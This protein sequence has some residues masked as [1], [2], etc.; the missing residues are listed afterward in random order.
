MIRNNVGKGDDNIGL[1]REV[2][3][4]IESKVEKKIVRCRKSTKSELTVE[5][6]RKSTHKIRSDQYQSLI[7]SHTNMYDVT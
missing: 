4:N 2:E 5:S 3:V 1:E 7:L 6:D